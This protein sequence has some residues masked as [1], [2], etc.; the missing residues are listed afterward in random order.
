MG[1]EPRFDPGQC[2]RRLLERR[3]RLGEGH[4]LLADAHRRELPGGAGR[5][6]HVNDQPPSPA[7]EEEAAQP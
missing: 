7:N 4:G 6:H 3:D 1:G 5:G 2:G